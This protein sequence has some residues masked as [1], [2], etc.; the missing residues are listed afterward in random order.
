MS[1]AALEVFYAS[2]L[3]LSTIV[4]VSFSLYVVLRLF[5]GQR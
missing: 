3:V 1:V 5:K 2:L 4:I